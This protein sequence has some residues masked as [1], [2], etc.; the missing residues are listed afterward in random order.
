MLAQIGLLRLEAR[1]RAGPPPAPP[2][3]V[4]PATAGSGGSRSR[5][6][7]RSDRAP[8]V[9]RPRPPRAAFLHQ[10]RRQMVMPPGPAGLELNGAPR[11]GHGLL[12]APVALQQSAAVEM[13]R[14]MAGVTFERFAQDR[15]GLILR[16]QFRSEGRRGAR[17]GPAFA[18]RAL[19]PAGPA[20]GPAAGAA[21]AIAGSGEGEPAL[22]TL[23]SSAWRSTASAA[24]GWPAST[25]STARWSCHLALRGSSSS[26]PR[27][28]H[29]LFE[30]PAALQQLAF[31]GS[32]ARHGQGGVRARRAR[33]L[34]P[35]RP[36]QPPAAAPPGARTDEASVRRARPRAGPPP[37]H[38]PGA[39][40]TAGSGSARK[41]K[42]P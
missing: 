24:S 20:P 40:P 19:P 1:R 31:G 41:Y 42:G 29:G 39:A 7:R 10:Q 5:R 36:S 13:E 38:L 4:A 11:G 8:D 12:E 17:A 23:R 32:G 33:P 34:Q 14:G 16:V 21:A 2:V 25:S 37:G 27:R 35:P 3:G 9:A 15:L 28:G 6:S 26:A 22:S 18:A 30:A